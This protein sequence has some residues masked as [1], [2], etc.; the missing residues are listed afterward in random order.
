MTKTKQ[1]SKKQEKTP[2]LKQNPNIH[3]VVCQIGDEEGEEDAGKATQLSCA[4]NVDMYSISVWWLFLLLPMQNWTQ[5]FY[6]WKFKAECVVVAI[7]VQ[8]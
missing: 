8:K 7:A 2:R 6:A 4:D 3:R 5:I 1:N